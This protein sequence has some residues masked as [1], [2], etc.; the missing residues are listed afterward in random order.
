MKK[1]FTVLFLMLAAPVAAF[2]SPFDSPEGDTFENSARI[3]DNEL[4][5]MRGGFQIGGLTIDFAVNTRTL[6]DGITQGDIVI[7]SLNL[8]GVNQADLHQ[9]IQVGQGN[10][11]AALDAIAQNPGLINI[12]QNT[13]DG[14]VIQRFNNLDISVSNLA[15]FRSQAL[16]PSIDFQAVNA[17]R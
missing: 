12:V 7:N 9:V 13:L 6:I 1:F 14:T 16:T 5:G 2:A 15:F 8:P 11:A 3:T 17:L 10:N 4:D